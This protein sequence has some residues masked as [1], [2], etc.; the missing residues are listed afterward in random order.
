MN[1]CGR[2]PHFAVTTRITRGVE[3]QYNFKWLCS[4]LGYSVKN[5]SAIYRGTLT[6]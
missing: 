5:V 3:Q 6:H 4:V 1:E 2:M